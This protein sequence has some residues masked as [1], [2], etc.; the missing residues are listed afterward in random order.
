MLL[1]KHATRRSLIP[2][3]L[4]C[5][6]PGNNQ[7]L[8]NTN[9]L[10]ST[11]PPT[12]VVEDKVAQSKESVENSEEFLELGDLE[13]STAVDNTKITMTSKTTPEVQTLC[14]YEKN[15]RIVSVPLSYG[16]G[17]ANP[18]SWDEVNFEN[19]NPM[20]PKDGI[21]ATSPSK[22]IDSSDSRP[23]IQSEDMDGDIVGPSSPQTDSVDLPKIS[24]ART[25]DELTAVTSIMTSPVKTAHDIQ[26]SLL[27]DGRHTLDIIAVDTSEQPGLATGAELTSNGSIL[28][29]SGTSE[30]LSAI[31]EI[32]LDQAA[33]NTLEK[34][35]QQS[36]F[37]DPETD[38][39]RSSMP[40]DKSVIIESPKVNSTA[41]PAHYDSADDDTDEC[42]ETSSNF[43]VEDFYS[44]CQFHDPSDGEVLE[45]LMNRKYDPVEIENFYSCEG[46]TIDDGRDT[47]I[48]N[49]EPAEIS[50]SASKPMKESVRQTRSTSRLS[51]DTSLL[52]DFL[53][54]A[55][56]SKAARDVNKDFQVPV[57]IPA[58]VP[59]PIP[60]PRRSP[61]KALSEKD[62][63]SPSP[64]N[65][66][67]RD[68][69][70][71]LGTSPGNP[72][73]EA[74]ELD[75][76]NSCR[77][78]T[79]KRLFA[80]PRAAAGAP[81]C[82]PVRR[83]DGTEPI[84]LPK[85]QA[86]E[87]AN[88]TRANTRRNKGQSK[89]PRLALKSLVADS[90]GDMTV[91]TISRA[92]ARAVGWD[93]TLVYYQDKSVETEGNGKEETRPKVRRLRNLGATNGTPAPKKLAPAAGSANG[94]SAP[95]RRGRSK[96]KSKS[97]SKS[98][99]TVASK[100]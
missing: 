90:A 51:D 38:Q 43:Q 100:G 15:T 53:S 16:D 5:Q 22:S 46:V 65:P 61:R 94:M 39:R 50:Q 57:Y 21:N 93:E 17:N 66:K 78:S 33:I 41:T 64:Q 25:P 72:T 59:S 7:R 19:P 76:L 6:V 84:V 67:R 56:A 24:E 30:H 97:K 91:A 89:P 45:F 47:N 4:K 26:P 63:N 28:H 70:N 79:R 3:R 52:Q 37:G 95:K 36:T 99:S 12:H 82:I 23:I 73:L 49:T 2:D 98:T 32:P 1:G 85:S 88:I 71:R 92:D 42:S 29:L 27:L 35:S 8:E 10:P 75:A 11:S 31:K 60:S 62:K 54:R 83:P 96:S 18:S 48:A 40:K 9:P 69:A 44:D 13:E 55:Q 77:R 87:L 34:S 58:P 14:F 20:S 86:Q 80:P 68:L 81:S 74:G